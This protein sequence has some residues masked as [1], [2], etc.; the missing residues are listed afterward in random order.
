M[1]WDL[2]VYMYH[3]LLETRDG[4]KILKTDLIGCGDGSWEIIV[5]VGE[6]WL[7][8]KKEFEYDV[9]GSQG[10]RSHKVRILAALWIK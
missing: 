4:S 5:Q 10:L 8:K 2:F 7:L 9:I 3:H 1:T 6:T